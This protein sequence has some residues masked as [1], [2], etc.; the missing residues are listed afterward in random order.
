[1]GVVVGGI[2]VTSSADGNGF[3]GVT[4]TSSADGSGCREHHCRKQS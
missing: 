2:T 3:R 4:L 1:M